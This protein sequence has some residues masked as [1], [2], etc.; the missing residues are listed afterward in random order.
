MRDVI[1]PERGPQAPE[2]EPACKAAYHEVSQ[3]PFYIACQAPLGSD[4]GSQAWTDGKSLSWHLRME[5]P[6]LG[7]SLI[8]VL[9]F[10]LISP[11]GKEQSCPPYAKGET[12]DQR[13]WVVK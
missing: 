10:S 6:S 8:Q 13:G 11:W 7:A 12:E 1:E 9:L 4:I 5:A 3:G 2:S